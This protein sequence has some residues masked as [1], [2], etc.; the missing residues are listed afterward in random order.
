[1]NANVYSPVIASASENLPGLRQEP[2]FLTTLGITV[3]TIRVD[4][5]PFAVPIH[6]DDLIVKSYLME[7]PLLV[8]VARVQAQA[9]LLA[10]AQALVR[11]LS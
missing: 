1:M 10:P 5:R 9:Q 3:R 2:R 8:L 4:W 6:S 7:S 11:L